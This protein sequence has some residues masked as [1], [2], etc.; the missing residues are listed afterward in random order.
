MNKSATILFILLITL[1]S[2]KHSSAGIPPTFNMIVKNITTRPGVNGQDSIILW[3]VYIQQTNYGQP[4]V[5]PF[6]FCCAQ[7]AW[8]FNKNIIQNPSVGNIVLTNLGA[9]TDF[10]SGLRPPTFSTDTITNWGPNTGLLRTSGNLPNS[11]INFF[12]NPNFPGTKALRMKLTT[13][14]HRWNNAPLNLRWKL[15]T[16]PNT[17]LAYFIQNLPGPDSANPQ[18][19][20]SLLDTVQNQYLID[21]TLTPPI[22]GISSNTTLVY[23]GF[24]INFADNSSNFPSGWIWSFPGGTPAF[25]SSANPVVYYYSPGTY[26][27]TLITLNSGGS[28]TLMKPDYVTVMP[29]CPVTWSNTLT[30]TDPANFKDSLK[31]GS[32]PGG[33]VNVDSCHGEYPLTS[34][35]VSGII[36][37]RFLHNSYDSKTDIRKD[38]NVDKSWTIKFQPSGAGYPVNLSWVSEAFPPEGYYYLKDTIS[39]TLININ[40][41]EQSNCT[42]T[43]PGIKT[44]KIEYSKRV[45]INL[46]VIP[47]GFYFPLFNQLSRRDTVSIYLRNA[48]S[49]F[50][51]VDSSKGIIDSNTFSNIFS[52]YNT[53]AG[54]YYI[55][56]KHLNSIE[57]WSKTDGLNI[58]SNQQVIDYD[59]TA[60]AGQ[61]YFNNLKLKGEKYC[62]YGGD[63]D[64]NGFID[65]TD[66]IFILNEAKNFV[67]GSYL[68]ADL[69]GDSL[70]D[71]SD[72]SLCSNNVANFIRVRRP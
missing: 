46:T 65:L 10:P 49:P 43:N 4:G 8:Y 14:G 21:S 18:F 31:F 47:E 57:T 33:S 67:S 13:N 26:P 68:P 59:F 51:I 53:P 5:D 34:T 35:P 32:S 72:V 54:D 7:Y 50:S 38:T 11:S 30:L 20:Q 23:A 70:V 24:R 52:F 40:M 60:S 64:K 44:L 48:L 66:L 63:V 42:V 6:E 19:A 25:S 17:F 16:A 36:D 1:L 3:D 41:R 27:V 69:N 12:I 15:G 22:A 39:G 37:F 62:L 56:V 2:H 45:D 71:L 61:A 28:D 9:Q 29:N 55:N 58:L